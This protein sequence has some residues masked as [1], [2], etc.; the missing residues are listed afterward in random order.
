MAKEKQQIQTSQYHAPCTVL[1]TIYEKPHCRSYGVSTQLFGIGAAT[2]ILQCFPPAYAHLCRY[3]EEAL[4]KLYGY[5]MV[6]RDTDSDGTGYLLLNIP[7]PSRRRPC[8]LPAD[9]RCRLHTCHLL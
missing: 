8:L 3:T 4:Q 1:S 2:R 5:D 6:R 9:C 7:A